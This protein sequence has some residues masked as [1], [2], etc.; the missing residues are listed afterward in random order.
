MTARRRS[1]VSPGRVAERARYAGKLGRLA[2][3]PGRLDHALH[4]AVRL[5]AVPFGWRV[6][7]D[8]VERLPRDAAGRVVPCVVAAAPHRGWTDPFLVLLAWPRDAPHLAWFGDE[9]TM[10]R[11]WW[12]R[13][14]LPRLGM[15]PIPAQPSARSVDIH[16][17][18]AAGVLARG[19]CLV[20]FVEKGPPS[21]RGAT[22]TIAPGAAW[23]AGA[24]GVPI[25]PVALGGF[26]E[27]G[28]GTRF[29]VR[30]LAPIPPPAGFE[31]AVGE[32]RGGRA[33]PAIRAGRAT[34]AELAAALA[35][36]IAELEAWSL[37]VN[38]RRPLPGLRRLFR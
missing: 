11:S 25:V 19:C 5:A 34:T 32:R 28:L 4:L 23:L 38:R 36:P 30:F 24:G 26:L 13:R 8:G 10:T 35:A 2:G 18:A 17:A 29:R 37:R 21:P 6:V 27:M 12:R 22:R 1:A 14:L 7:V 31:G 16:L 3:T 15:I 20:V 9:V 33:V